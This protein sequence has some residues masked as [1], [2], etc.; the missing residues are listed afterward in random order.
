MKGFSFISGRPK[1]LQWPSPFVTIRFL[2]ISHCIVCADSFLPSAVPQ[3]SRPKSLLSATK[4]QESFWKYRGHDIYTN[5][6]TPSVVSRSSPAVLLIHGFGCSTTY[7]RE[8]AA[9]LVS[10]GYEVHSLDLL[11]QGKSDKPGRADGIEYSIAL[12]ANLVDSYVGENVRREDIVLV[13]NSLGS[14]VALTAATGDFASGDGG[15]ESFLKKRVRGICMFNCGVGLNSRGIAKE[16]RLTPTQSLLINSLYSVLTFFIFENRWLLAYVLDEVVTKDLL[17]NTL[18]SLYKHDPTRVDDELVDSF[19]LPA[20]EEGSPEA[21][22]Q[23]Y[24]NDPGMTPFELHE[25]HD[26]FLADMPIQL[27]WG[28]QDYVTPLDGGVGQFYL[29]LG[30]DED[31]NVSFQKIEGGH[32]PFDDNPVES[33]RIMLQWLDG[34]TA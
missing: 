14:L 32:V 10:G 34:I 27:V 20:K 3:S 30:A 11:G 13:G 23:I 33:N 4:V 29:G 28:D 24:C 17:C 6:K 26:N 19:Y 31:S 5:I 25:K 8:T 15:G 16:P 9:A 12:W 7:W 18:K 1:N 2:I 22:S 21:L